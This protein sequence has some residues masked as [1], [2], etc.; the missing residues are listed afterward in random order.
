VVKTFMGR[1]VEAPAGEGSDFLG[2]GYVGGGGNFPVE[3]RGQRR[4][5]VVWEGRGRRGEGGVY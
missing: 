3:G 1:C 4:V 5:V 2:G